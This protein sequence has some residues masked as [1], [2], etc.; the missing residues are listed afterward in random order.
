M[1][2]SNFQIINTYGTRKYETKCRKKPEKPQIPPTG[3]MAAL[4]VA[5]VVTDGVQVIDVVVG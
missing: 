1:S 4:H 2:I 3:V 5:V